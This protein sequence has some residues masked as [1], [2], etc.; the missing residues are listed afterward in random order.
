MGDGPVLRES[1]LGPLDDARFA[2]GRIFASRYRIV[3]LLG[4][5]GMGE[6]YRA[7]DLRLGQP[8]A[9]KLLSYRGG[10]GPEG[11]ARFTAE[12][13]LARG[14][15][16]PNVCRV[17]DIGEAEGWTYLSMEYVD[18]ET[19]ASLLRRIGRLPIEKA[20]DTAK[21]LCA[22]LAAAHDRGVLHRDLKPS[23]I[24]ID[25]RG[26]VRIMDFGLAVSSGD[27]SVRGI[28][29][30]PSYMAPEQLVGDPVTDRTDLYS[31]GLVLYEIFVGAV[32]FPAHSIAERAHFGH[33]APSRTFPAGLDSAVERAVLACLEPNPADRPQ[34]ALAVAGVLSEG[35][36]FAAALAD[37][38]VPLPG[39]VAASAN[40]GALRPAVAWPL[41]IAV[42]G[43]TIAVASQ[44]HTFTVESSDIPQQPDVLAQRARDIMAAVGDR[45]PP[46]D[47]EFWFRR[48]PQPAASSAADAQAPPIRFIYRESSRYLVPENLFHFV[49]EIDPPADSPGMASVTLDNVGRLLRFSSIRNE[50]ARRSD[51]ATPD[52]TALFHAAG[53]EQSAF[54]RVNSDRT[55]LVPHDA[56][57]TWQQARGVSPPAVVTAASLAGTPVHFDASNDPAPLITRRSMLASRRP[58]TTEAL[59]WVLIV[60]GFATAGVLARR[61]LRGGDVDRSSA[62]KL[63]LFVGLAGVFMVMLRAHHVPSGLD[64]ITFLL[65]ITGWALV[66]S[67]FTWLLYVGFE[68]H[69]R[70]LWPDTLISWT[71]LMTGRFDDP[72]VGRDVL[73]GLLCGIV[74]T[75]VLLLRVHVTHRLAPDNLIAPALES[76]RSGR[77]FTAA[78][79]FQIADA[80]QFALGGLFFMLLLKLIMRRMWIAASAWVLLVAPVSTGAALGVGASWGLDLVVA[81]ALGVFSLLVV[82]RVGLLAALV[83]LIFERLVTA[84]PITFDLGSWYFGSSLL[85]LL[86][87]IAVAISAFM[88]ALGEHSVLGDQVVDT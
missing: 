22:G 69:V 21:Q 36:P 49:T 33:D 37:G 18:G 39:M 55:P 27:T 47:S 61:N 74:T 9:L 53:L 52:W 76:L 13:R 84:V 44:A 28:A 70:R 62:R 71:R 11:V 66:W 63:S 60:M 87:V 24:M 68:P 65:G 72:Q 23:N 83:M 35:D 75:A 8:V 31:L 73:A 46:V 16:H 51:N 30:T 5:G 67:V 17:Y 2:P 26:R 80:V 54:V 14:I 48:A 56:V 12:V 34:S 77:Y 10:Y 40:K 79:T 32:C 64:E 50:A 41:L 43:G 88:V 82:L 45:E 15:A 7:E 78:M 6:V 57:F 59:L 25:G 86:L 42:I 20:L 1:Q 38:R 3:S 4:R 85:V 58:P 81:V 29:G 19:L